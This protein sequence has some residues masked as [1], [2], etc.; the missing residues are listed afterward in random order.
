MKGKRT[1]LSCYLESINSSKVLPFKSILKDLKNKTIE[2]IG[3]VVTKNKAAKLL[4]LKVKIASNIIPKNSDANN[5]I[6][7]INT[8][9]L[10]MNKRFKL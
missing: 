5:P 4:N 10:S 3:P 8:N 7:A 9:E 6:I 2:R 1:S